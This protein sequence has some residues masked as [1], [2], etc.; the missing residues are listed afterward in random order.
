MKEW[1]VHFSFFIFHSSFELAATSSP[2]P[3]PSSL[4]VLKSLAVYLTNNSHGF[5]PV[6]FLKAVEKWEIEEYPSWAETSETEK[7]FS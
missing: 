6:C 1:A 7:P 4:A 5:K 2:V 3:C